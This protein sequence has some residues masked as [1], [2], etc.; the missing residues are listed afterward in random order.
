LEELPL[1][2]AT[3]PDVSDTSLEEDVGAVVVSVDEVSSEL[4]GAVVVVEVSDDEVS[5]ELLGAVVVVVSL[6]LPVSSVDVVVVDV[7]LPPSSGMQSSED[8]RMVSRLVI[9]DDS[10]TATALT[11]DLPHGLAINALERQPVEAHLIAATRVAL[12]VIHREDRLDVLVLTSVL[13]VAVVLV[14]HHGVVEPDLA[15]SLS[16]ALTTTQACQ[17]RV[18]IGAAGY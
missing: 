3:V 8:Q 7:P 1:D 9:G 6:S 13:G 10:R 11:V 17:E 2:G 14:Q 15:R 18:N 12:R 5:S 16:V 4:L